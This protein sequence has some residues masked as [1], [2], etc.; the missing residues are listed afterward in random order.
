MQTIAYGSAPDQVG[1]L[2]LP[3]AFRVPLVCL[4]HGGFWRMPYGR[5]QLHPMALDL[6]EAGLAVWNLEYRRVGP[7]GTPWPA[8]LEDV[9]GALSWLHT[10]RIAHPQIDLQR[11]SLVGHSAGGHLAFWAAAR[12]AHLS[13]R[14]R[15]AA[16]VGLAPLLDLMAAANANLGNGA[17]HA[18][19]GVRQWILHGDEDDAVPP[20]L[21]QSY[22]AE[23][24]AAGDEA[25]WVPLAHA[26][27]MALIDPRSQSYQVVRQC[28]VA[29]AQRPHEARY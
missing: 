4:F 19:L 3:A 13:Q 29:A 1:D 14:L 24:T 8:T 9:E 28:I 23:A 20:A 6:C 17:V 21:S 26:D 7:G 10:L 18:F 15:P 5:D 16:V 22:V 2:Y 12:A 25:T 11:L 27:H